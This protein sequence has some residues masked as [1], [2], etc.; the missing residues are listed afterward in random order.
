MTTNPTQMMPT[1]RVEQN[2]TS[3]RNQESFH[4][5]S[6]SVMEMGRP[7]DRSQIVMPDIKDRQS[8]QRFKNLNSIKNIYLNRE[9]PLF[10]KFE[11]FGK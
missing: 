6:N 7:E 9:P 2:G 1:T 3:V 8:Y 11:R 10:V 4:L 5:R